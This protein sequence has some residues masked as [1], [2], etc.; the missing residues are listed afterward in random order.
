MKDV[1]VVIDSTS[2]ELS[3]LFDE[4]GNDCPQAVLS[5]YP[6]IN[7]VH[8]SLEK[9]LDAVFP[10]RHSTHKVKEVGLEKYIQMT[11]LEAAKVLLPEFETALPLRWMGEASNEKIRPKDFDVSIEAENLMQS[12]VQKLPCIRS[13]LIEDIQAAYDGDP[14]A[15]SY[16]EV[17]MAYPGLLA[18]A[19]HRLA[20]ELYK[21][22]IPAIPRVMSEWIHTKT[23]CDIHPG[24]TIGKGFFVDH[25]TG[26]VI[27]ETAI[28]GNRVKLYQGVTIGAKSFPLDENGR[29][30]KHIR[31]HPEVEDDVIIYSN[32]TILGGKTVIGKGATI[33]GNVFL[34]KSVPANSMVTNQSPEPKIC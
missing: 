22:D 23:G 8:Q 15:H 7:S 2:K 6:N 9:L 25:P 5:A 13:A 31:R 10:G 32:A 3:K 20:H 14:A 27:G 18:I 1:S 34:M 4:S 19:S 11:L 28:I 17:M 33:G 12:F 16:A 26:V 24:A 30:I 21:L 29:P